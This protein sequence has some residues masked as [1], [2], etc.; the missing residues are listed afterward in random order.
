MEKKFYLTKRSL[1]YLALFVLMS[2][3]LAACSTVA[4][5]GRKQ[6][7]IIPNSSLLSMSFSQYDQFLKDNKI[8]ADQ[9][10]TAMIKR[11]G[12]KIQTAV[13][14]YF[15][16]K[17]MSKELDGFEWEFN[18]VE[19][20]QV[21][22]WCMPG[23]KVVFYTGI[24]PICKDETG[25]AVVMGHEV[26]HAIADHGGERMSQGL[27]AEF[28]GMALDKMLESKPAET[29][30]LAMTAFGIGAQHD[31][32][33]LTLAFHPHHLAD[34]HVGRVGPRCLPGRP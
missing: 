33:R 8:S 17:N 14:E 27:V 31:F 20:D 6:F 11:V 18:L 9:K 12:K 25:V 2:V 24:L 26:A 13:E 30:A 7:N 3:L 21:N 5:T 28:G 16:S 1:R 29:R 19:S 4:I 23:G 34:F 32:C 15:K 22:A 10:N